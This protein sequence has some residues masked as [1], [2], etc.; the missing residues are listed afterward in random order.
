MEPREEIVPTEC[1]TDGELEG[2]AAEFAAMGTEEAAHVAEL[3]Q[4]VVRRRL[5]VEALAAEWELPSAQVMTRLVDEQD[6]ET[7]SFFWTEFVL[8]PQACCW[9]DGLSQIAAAMK[10][11]TV[12]W[13]FWRV[14]RLG[15]PLL[16][17]VLF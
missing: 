12:R 2:L 11:V 1:L 8:T 15:T 5:I 13:L 7:R 17:P 10:P 14:P 4:F 6:P 9:I 16:P 3:R